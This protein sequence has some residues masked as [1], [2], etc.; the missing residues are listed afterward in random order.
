MLYWHHACIRKESA[1]HAVFPGAKTP[2]PV[3]YGPGIYARQPCQAHFR[4]SGNK[5]RGKLCSFFSICIRFVC[6]R[7]VIHKH[8]TLFCLANQMIQRLV[9][10][11]R[12]PLL[13][14]PPFILR[15]AAA[16]LP[17]LQRCAFVRQGV[18]GEIYRQTYIT[19]YPCNFS[20]AAS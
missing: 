8:L 20:N 7:L 14:S 19:L 12:I 13:I 4:K 10:H 18:E 1:G 17:A 16:V 2:D 11:G 3:L 5:V 15:P 9:I 6:C